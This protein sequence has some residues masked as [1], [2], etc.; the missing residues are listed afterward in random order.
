[1]ATLAAY[2]CFHLFIKL[3]TTIL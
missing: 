3:T 2:L 1:M